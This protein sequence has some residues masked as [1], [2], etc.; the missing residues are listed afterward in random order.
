[1][2][3]IG[4]IRNFSLLKKDKYK[5]EQTVTIT[6]RDQVMLSLGSRRISL[7]KLHSFFLFFF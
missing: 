1:M 5:D 7:R 2:N 3:N 4:K 6:S